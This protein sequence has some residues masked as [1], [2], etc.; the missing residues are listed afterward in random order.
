MMACMN[1]A[2]NMPLRVRDFIATG[3]GLYFAVVA[4]DLE[5]GRAP[6]FLRYLREANGLRKVNT[7][8]AN[9]LLHDEHSQY[10]WRS[11]NRQADLHGVPL[12]RIV[13]RYSA[14]E[15][16]GELIDKAEDPLERIAALFLRAC[17]D[18]GVRRQDMGVSGSLLLSCHHAASDI[19][20]VFYD[21]A[22][23]DAAR[24]VCDR[25]I[26]NEQ[27][28]WSRL[29]SEQWE[30]AYQRRGCELSLEQ[31]LWHERRKRN[32][33]MIRG[34]KLDLSLVRRSPLAETG[35]CV[36]QRRVQVEGIVADDQFAFD[37]PAIWRIDHADVDRVVAWTP[38]YTGHARKGERIEAAG[39]LEQCQDGKR[40][41]IVGATREAEGEWI[42]VIT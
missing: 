11:P 8:E 24:A 10:L 40:Q 39:W 14:Q 22:A 6:C 2:N 26:R 17:R 41:L 23:F 36:K 35:P 25:E 13:R 7:Q 38:T 29:N 1:T 31:Y 18:A 21:R 20:T 16:A 12:E 37:T 32:K 5:Q 28:D 30:Q 15:R 3:E 42:R 4:D 9:R 34:V 27:S 19:D 33:V